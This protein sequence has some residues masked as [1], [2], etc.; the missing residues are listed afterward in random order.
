M[1]LI[2]SS[3]GIFCCSTVILLFLLGRFNQIVN[4][5]QLSQPERQLRLHE[6]S[7]NSLEIASSL[8]ADGYGEPLRLTIPALK[9]N[10]GV[11]PVGLAD[12]GT[13]GVPKNQNN[14]AWLNI[15]PR[16]GEDG[17]SIITGHYGWKDNKPSVFDN[18]YKLR[19]DDKIYVEDVDGKITA[20]VVRENRRYD[21]MADASAVFASE[22]GGAHL[23]LITCE[24]AWDDDTKSYPSRLVV[25]ADKE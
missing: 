2:L 6:T 16:P 25:F 11:E 15:G 1:L 18:L 14:V 10:A 17:S 4:A 3:V 20:F 12:D 8:L 13:V 24:G 9:I 5:K 21:A 23:N 7:G 22:D 19:K